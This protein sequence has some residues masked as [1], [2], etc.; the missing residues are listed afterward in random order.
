MFR[1][2]PAE[3]RTRRPLLL[4]V[5]ALLALTLARP[6]RATQIDVTTTTDESN[7]DGDCSLRE[8]IRAASLN[9]AQDACPAGSSGATDTISLSGGATYSL[10]IPPTGGDTTGQN[11]D[12]DVLDNAGAALDL[13]IDG[14]AVSGGGLRT[15]G[16]SAL[17]IDDTLFQGN[18][19]GSDPGGAIHFAGTAVITSSSFVDN[20]APAGGAIENI[21]Q[22]KNAL[23]VGN[24]CFVG[25]R[26]D[27]IDSFTAASQLAKGNWWGVAG[28]PSAGGDTVVGNDATTGFLAA[29]PGGC[30]PQELVTR[31]SFS[32]D[33]DLPP[34]WRGR[35]LNFAATDGAKVRVEYGRATGAVE[36]DD[37]SVLLQ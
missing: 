3:V 34:R 17:T 26:D 13:V 36:F 18:I 27:A 30:W 19:A 12:L 10:T 15:G 11:G 9:T 8:A 25:N 6:A 31:G 28:G 21:A 2:S 7:S 24:S 16:S 4:L 14:A 23:Q 33:G 37:V 20:D 35:K 29:P 1:P 22:T 5:L 32:T